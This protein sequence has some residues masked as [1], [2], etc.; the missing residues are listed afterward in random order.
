VEATNR[1]VRP[2]DEQGGG[3]ISVDL[4]CLTSEQRKLWDET[5]PHLNAWTDGT[6]CQATRLELWSFEYI[7][8]LEGDQPSWPPDLQADLGEYAR[9][10]QEYRANIRAARKRGEL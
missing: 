3:P 4:A 10:L 2:R 7:C 1:G 5:F 8:M 6:T 9:M